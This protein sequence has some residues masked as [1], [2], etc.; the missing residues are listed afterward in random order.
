[1]A[2]LSTR[3][4]RSSR[5]YQRRPG[6]VWR[7]R[8]RGV[9][10]H[11]RGQQAAPRQQRA[12]RVAAPRRQLRGRGR[13]APSHRR[14]DPRRVPSRHLPGTRAAAAQ[15]GRCSTSCTL[16][17]VAKRTRPCLF[18]AATA[19]LSRWE[20]ELSALSPHPP[21]RFRAT[22]TLTLTL[23]T[24]APLEASSAAPSLWPR[25]PTLTLTHHPHP[26][27]SPH[28]HPSPSPSPHPHPSP[29]PARALT[30]TFHPP[31]TPPPL[32]LLLP[33]PSSSSAGGPVAR[34]QSVSIRSEGRFLLFCGS[35]TAI[36]VLRGSRRRSPER[37]PP[38]GPRQATLP[39]PPPPL[40]V[41]AAAAAAATTTT[42]VT[43]T[44]ARVAAGGR[45]K[46][47]PC[48]WTRGAH[49]SIWLDA[50][51]GRA[52]SPRAFPTAPTGPS[53][54]PRALTLRDPQVRA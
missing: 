5:Q 22:L 30:L 17:G 44:P 9:H 6:A 54:P 26:S 37:R 29:H 38:R 24:T 12:G 27:A 45:D 31:L 28:Q 2:A 46:G 51:T 13:G 35:L 4:S 43:T 39:S 36:S 21:L 1:M 50:S 16:H 23:F 11:R 34:A 14:G 41:Q 19:A 40:R 10:P 20:G 33:S 42:T 3:S 48:S 15:G 52:A 32:T 25:H 47:T 18:A 7:G 49:T 8:Y 53:Q